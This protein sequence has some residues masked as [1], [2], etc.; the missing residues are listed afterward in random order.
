MARDTSLNRNYWFCK[1]NNKLEAEEELI[2]VKTTGGQWQDYLMGKPQIQINTPQGNANSDTFLDSAVG[3]QY[4][5][6]MHGT[7]CLGEVAGHV[8]LFSKVT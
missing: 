5:W 3:L 7:I 8:D 1:L 4:C 6:P 2:K